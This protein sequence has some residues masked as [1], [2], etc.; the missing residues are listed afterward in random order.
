MNNV[1]F[2]II[3]PHRNSLDTLPRLLNSIPKSES[4]EPIIVDNSSTPI[5]K[6]DI[7]TDR[8]FKLLYSD[9]KT[10]AGGARNI[11]IE[12]ASGEWLIF[13]DADD[14]FT[15][16]AFEIFVSAKNLDSDLIFFKSKSVYDDTLM[17]S[18]RSTSFNEIID[19]YIS[20]EINGNYVGCFI[21]VPWAKMIKR[22][23]VKNNNIKFDEVVT[24]NDIMF[25]ILT[26]Y[27]SKSYNVIPK[28]V[29]VVTTRKGSLAHRE[30]YPAI[31]SRFKVNLRRNKFLK[32]HNLSS[33]QA[34]VMIYIYTALKHNFKSF[35]S[36][37]ILSIKYRQNI[38]IG[39]KNW[40]SSY[41][42][43]KKN[44][45]KNKTYFTS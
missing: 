18:D 34:S 10:Y 31:L 4:I 25:S 26:W 16:E 6:N 38:F 11:G 12:S 21:V 24:A 32:E 19:K 39:C 40:I 1:D 9:P 8:Y 43:Y 28:E 45:N 33:Y 13:A 5:T 29:Y 44:H 2:S 41:K 23:L 22:K 3:I 14:F 37:I 7:P 42:H 27:H 36:F 30:D 17:P 20:Q 15:T 35:L